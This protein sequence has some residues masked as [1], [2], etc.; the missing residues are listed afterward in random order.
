MNQTNSIVRLQSHANRS[1]TGRRS[2]TATRKLVN[3]LA[4][5][6]GRPAQQAQRHPRGIW[7]NHT[8]QE[9][10]HE[11]VLAWTQAEGLRHTFTH[12]L[13]LSVKE[14]SLTA[15]AYQK[16]L[17]AHAGVLTDWHLI[18]HEDTRH[19]HAHVVTFSDDPMRVKSSGLYDWW[20]GLRQALESVQTAELTQMEQASDWHLA[21]D[22]AVYPEPKLRQQPHWEWELEL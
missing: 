6:R 9:V 1:V 4:Y 20:L 7:L 12:Q 8:G 14:A 16:T 22:T 17:A 5:G 3:Y 10:S 11:A 15:A 13:I 18:G 2:V 21:P 19:S